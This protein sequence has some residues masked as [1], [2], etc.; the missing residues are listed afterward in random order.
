MIEYI[1]RR[2]IIWAITIAIVFG[3]SK[4]IANSTSKAL[5]KSVEKKLLEL[6]DVNSENEEEIDED[7]IKELID[8]DVSR[9]GGS[10]L[11]N[12]RENIY[13]IFETTFTA[14]GK[15]D[16]IKKLGK[17]IFGFTFVNKKV[18]SQEEKDFFLRIWFET[19]SKE[20]FENEL[21]KFD[22]MVDSMEAKIESFETDIRDLVYEI[23][24]ANKHKLNL[25]NK[26][27]NLELKIEKYTSKNK[28]KKVER[29][30]DKIKEIEFFIKEEDK[31]IASKNHDLNLLKIEKQQLDKILKD[32]VKALETKYENL[33]NP[34]FEL[35]QNKV[36]LIGFEKSFK[37][38]I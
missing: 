29:I 24:D 27:E 1:I 37:L 3:I 5:S 2:A 26:I 15:A 35:K 9:H 16:A 4:A 10:Y 12:F 22:L 17:K 20:I 7:L 23:S 31:I 30:K 8:V 18:L 32:K 38:A 19:Y 11:V 28:P 25:K 13:G 36:S 34:Q 14:R 6:G 33:K 21:Y